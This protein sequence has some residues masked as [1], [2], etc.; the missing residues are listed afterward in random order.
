MSQSTS[1]N[2]AGRCRTKLR[3]LLGVAA[4]SLGF[5]NTETR[6]SAHEQDVIKRDTS[7]E[8][9]MKT[10]QLLRAPLGMVRALRIG[11]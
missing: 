5:M 3:T 4:P 11:P 9:P 8:T 1:L 10:L 6:S 2:L 7:Q